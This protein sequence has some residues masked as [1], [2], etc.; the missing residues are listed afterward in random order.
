[1]KLLRLELLGFKSF[2]HRT[3]LRFEDGITCIVGPN[4]CGKS[5]IVDAITWVLGERGTKSLRV[6]DM[7]DVIFHGSNGKRPVNVGEVTIDFRDGDKD[8]SVCRRIYRDGV[9][10]YF[11]NAT[12]VR[13]KDIQDFFLGTG[14]GVNTY[15]IVEQGRIEQFITM[16]PQERRLLVEEA[17]GITRFEEK[18]R[19]AVARMEEVKANLERVEDI[20]GEVEGSFA[21]AHEEWQR[22]KEHRALSER[23]ATVEMEI[24]ADGWRRIQKRVERLE[25]RR[26]ELERDRVEMEQKLETV[27]GQI[28]A[29]E[30]EFSLSDKIIRALEVDLKAHEKDLEGRLLEMDHLSQEEGILEGER[31]VLLEERKEME[32][33]KGRIGREVE[34]LKTKKAEEASKFLALEKAAGELKERIDVL[35]S[36]LSSFDSA[37]ETARERLFIATSALAETKNRIADAERRKLERQRREEIRLQQKIMLEERL[38]AIEQELGPKKAQR[39]ELEAACDEFKRAEVGLLARRDALQAKLSDARRTVADVTSDLKV[40]EA[41]LRQIGATAKTEKSLP[42]HGPRLMDLITFR[43]DFEKSLER[44]FVSEMEYDVINDGDANAIARTVEGRPSNYIFFPPGGTFLLDGGRVQVGVVQVKTVQEGL[45]RIWQ[46]EDGVFVAGEVLIDSRGFIL[47]EREGRSR[48]I[49]RFASRL[50]MER[51]VNGLKKEL[52][53]C[54]RSMEDLSS[55]ADIVQKACGEAKAQR[56]AKE[57]ALEMMERELIAL[58]T[59]LRTQSGSLANL[60]AALDLDGT[61]SGVSSLALPEALAVARRGRETAEETLN[62]VRKEQETFK[63]TYEKE[64]GR[65]HGMSVEL[66][67]LKG[68][69][70]GLTGEL[71]RKEE[72]AV[73]LEQELVRRSERF[74][75]IEEGMRGRSLKKEG[76]EREYE[77]MRLAL[78]R[79][80]NRYESLKGHLADLHMEKVSLAEGRDSLVAE[81]ERLRSRDEQVEK[82]L[83]VLAEKVGVIEDRLKTVYGIDDIGSLAPSGNKQVEEER[84]L[85]QRQINGLGEVNFRAEKEYEELSGRRD[86]LR[87][88]RQDLEESMEALKKTI[89]RIEG[90]SKD[91]FLETFET[92]NLAFKRYAPLLFKGGRGHLEL[93]SETAGVE[94]YAQPPGKRVVRMELLSGGEKALV[95]LSFLLSLMD[96]RPS[97]FSLLDEIDAPLDDANLMGLMEIMRD[98][99]RKTQIVFIT[100]NRIT[101]TSSNALYGI[102]MEEEG[103]SK[104]VSVRL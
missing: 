94:L 53:S 75:V 33:K 62:V 6:K 104:T 88:Q 1:M 65:W 76:L 20:Q 102:T 51:E 22:W 49:E 93:S 57:R 72:E 4:G 8:F 18:K 13:L 67:R 16:K 79:E 2:L 80:V 85:L 54:T 77:E 30:Y 78:E 36:R 3:V 11:L 17:S 31:K 99:S 64:R 82:E 58:T 69:L 73:V 84:E 47:A 50:K 92:I 90:L 61:D 7:G 83:A 70:G 87:K 19:E 40:K 56:E 103:V 37:V 74:K 34:S 39:A 91:K 97:P 100:H 25:E 66:E 71:A 35:T 29:K 68:A 9:N 23:L 81:K 24:L 89:S 48:A 43:D 5:N 98:M 52:L 38:Q 59:E 55:Q 41:F 15:A 14:I 32:E 21:K 27:S 96:T 101:M 86:F 10:E 44:F 46:G 26:K 60:D 42:Y 63:E 95:S 45:Q 12:Q 28:A